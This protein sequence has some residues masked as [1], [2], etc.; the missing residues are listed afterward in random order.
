LF[1]LRYR[2]SRKVT[3]RRPATPF[4]A[5]VCG[6]EANL[7]LARQIVLS[8]DSPR[9]CRFFVFGMRAFAT[10]LFICTG[11]FLA[12]SWRESSQSLDCNVGSGFPFELNGSALVISPP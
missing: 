7:P 6:S 2:L 11:D 3:L 4:A 5:I 10:Q 1:N 12:C 9:P 8:E